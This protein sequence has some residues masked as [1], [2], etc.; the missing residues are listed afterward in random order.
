VRIRGSDRGRELGDAEVQQLHLAV[1]GEEDV[2][3]LHVPV[4][5]PTGVGGGEA[6]GHLGCPFQRGAEGRPATG[7]AVAQRLSLEQLGDEVGR[8]LVLAEVV[9]R[10]EVGMV[11]RARKARLLLEA[12]HQLGVAREHLVDHLERDLPAE[13][14]VACPVDLRHPAGAQ[15]RQHLVGSDLESRTEAHGWRVCSLGDARVTP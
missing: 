1:R 4:D 10:D 8:T 3:R 14:A 9:D 7:E 6:T 5:D 13:P 11:Q 12:A 2:V 15:G